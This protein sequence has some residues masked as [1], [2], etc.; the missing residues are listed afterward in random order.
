M[1][2]ADTGEYNYKKEEAP[3]SFDQALLDEFFS[4]IAIIAV[5]L[6]KDDTRDINGDDSIKREVSKP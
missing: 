4:I 6:T 5:R 2:K 3:S 1:V